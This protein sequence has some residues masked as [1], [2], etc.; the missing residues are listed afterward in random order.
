MLVTGAPAAL[1]PNSHKALTLCSRVMSFICFILLFSVS[2]LNYMQYLHVACRSTV[3]Q[4]SPKLHSV[5]PLEMKAGRER[6]GQASHYSQGMW[7]SASPSWAQTCCFSR[8]SEGG[9]K[10]WGCVLSFF[11]NEG[12]R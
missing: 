1:Q 3:R 6:P 11:S 10:G 7:T 5:S 2:L 8:V 4:V 12:I 9:P